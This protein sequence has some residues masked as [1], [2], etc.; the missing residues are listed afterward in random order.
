MLTKIIYIFA[1]ATLLTTQPIKAGLLLLISCLII[2]I[3]IFKKINPLLSFFIFLIYV[4]GILILFIYLSCLDHQTAKPSIWKTTKILIFIAPTLIL[5][6]Q[7]CTY[8]YPSLKTL[9]QTWTFVTT[10][11]YY[12]SV[13][14][15]LI[16]LLIILTIITTSTK[17]A[18]R[19]TYNI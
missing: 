4:R 1:S 18:L 5:T 13:T 7:H 16:C 15:L 11:N 2:L 19:K 12:L 3:T 17:K 9:N 14:F 6:H 8:T 10:I